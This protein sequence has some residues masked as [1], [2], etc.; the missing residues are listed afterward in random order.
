MS[1]FICSA[2]HFLSVEKSIIRL[3]ETPDYYITPDLYNVYPELQDTYKT[4]SVVMRF[5]DQLRSISVLCVTY[6]Y[7]KHFEDVNKEIAKEMKALQVRQGRF[8]LLNPVALS[9]A[10]DCIDYQI[11]IDKLEAVRPL[12]EE[13]QK[14]MQFLSILKNRLSKHIIRNLPE[15]DQA[16]WEVK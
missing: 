13:E 1:S 16:D 5:M 4:H 2:K 9:K 14:A 3:F 10:L 11:E 8:E 12:T 7:A 15:Y 6:Q